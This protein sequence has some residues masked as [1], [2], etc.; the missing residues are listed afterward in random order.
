MKKNIEVISLIYKSTEY[1]NFIVKQLNNLPDEINDWQIKTR[2]VANDATQNVLDCLKTL[3]IPHT[4][5]NDEYPNHFYLNRVYRCWNFAGYSSTYDNICFVNSDMMFSTDWFAN[6]LKHH[7]GINIPCSRLVESGKMHSGTY[8]LEKD[9]GKSPKTLKQEEF[10]QFSNK[11]KECGQ[12]KGGGLYMPC[13]FSKERF[14]QSGMYP[15]GNIFKSEG[16]LVAGF[17]NDRP[18]YMSGDDYLFKK[19]ENEYNMKHITVFDSIVYHIQE[20]E[21]DEE[22]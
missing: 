22:I 11:I 8:G 18:V 15:E 7:D 13:I 14:V 2:I 3:N 4:I 10:N 19:L 16:R 1:L 5:Y 9:F 12:V 17:P 20:G 21:K 6:L